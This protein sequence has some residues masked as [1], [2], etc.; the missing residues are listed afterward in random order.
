M[1]FQVDFLKRHYSDFKML[2]MV[3]WVD[4][5]EPHFSYFETFKMSLGVDCSEWHFEG[6]KSKYCRPKWI[7]WNGIIYT[8]KCKKWCSGW[9]S[10][11][12]IFYIFKP[13]KSA[14][15]IGEGGRILES[16]FFRKSKFIVDSR[17][18]Y[19]GF[20]SWEVRIKFEEEVL[21]HS[22]CWQTFL[23]NNKL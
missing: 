12:S 16:Y 11:S 1:S 4:F 17:S 23:H 15:I 5:S 7:A 8:L 2:K 10:Q 14:T 6:L 22:V 13:S 19:P 20:F 9:I 18:I 3:F 21:W